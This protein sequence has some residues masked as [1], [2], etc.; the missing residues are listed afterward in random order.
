MNAVVHRQRSVFKF[1]YC[2]P[3][4]ST[5]KACSIIKES[6]FIHSG[7]FLNIISRSFTW[8]LKATS[9]PKIDSYPSK[10]DQDLRHPLLLPCN[11]WGEAWPEDPLRTCH[12]QRWG[13]SAL[14]KA[15]K[16][17]RTKSQSSWT[18]AITGNWGCIADAPVSGSRNLT[19]SR[20]LVTDYINSIVITGFS[21]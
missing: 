17:V 18:S 7:N 9:F 14:L 5:T 8:Y 6:M 11:Q 12:Y 4:K 2:V 15:L 20:S 16:N 21:L 13:K 10:H 3:S 19:L 1:L